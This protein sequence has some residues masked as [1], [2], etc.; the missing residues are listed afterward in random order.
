MPNL[1]KCPGCQA[2]LEIQLKHTYAL[3]QYDN[4]YWV[5]STV[6]I[7]YACALCGQALALC[8]VMDAL[9]QTEEQRGMTCS[10]KVDFGKPTTGFWDGPITVAY[11]SPV[12]TTHPGKGNYVRFGSISAN[13]WFTVKAGRSWKEAASSA[14]KHLVAICRVPAVVTIE[15]SVDIEP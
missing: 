8:D 7:S 10:V 2:V 14:K 13:L 3:T 6:D 12:V 4:G 9:Q 11:F 15:R 5:K 1:Q